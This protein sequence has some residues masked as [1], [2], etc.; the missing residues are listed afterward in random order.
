MS[1]TNGVLTALPAPPGYIV[2]FDNP[3]RQSNIATYWIVGVGNAL[4]LLFLAQHLYVNSVVRR[5]LGLI[6]GM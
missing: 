5:K 2:D 3:Q 4:S 6:D 1:L